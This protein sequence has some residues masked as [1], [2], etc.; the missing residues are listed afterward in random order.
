MT[1]QFSHEECM[2]L[3]ADIRSSQLGDWTHDIHTIES[4]PARFVARAKI[5]S[6]TEVVY[7]RTESGARAWPAANWDRYAVPRAVKQV[8]PEQLELF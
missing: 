4:G 6:G 8:E 5:P 2:S 7:Y 3:L 1:R